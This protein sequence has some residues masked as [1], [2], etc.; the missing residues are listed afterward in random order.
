MAVKKALN[1]LP[2]LLAK[3]RQLLRRCFALDKG[4]RIS[5]TDRCGLEP[6]NAKLVKKASF[7]NYKCV[8]ANWEPQSVY[9]YSKPQ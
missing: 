3:F 9:D 1:R 6:A 4:F 2:V 7:C 5:G 8:I